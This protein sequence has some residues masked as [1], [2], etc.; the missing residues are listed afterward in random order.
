MTDEPSR[1]AIATYVMARPD[2]P[3]ADH[4][5]RALESRANGK[6]ILLQLGDRFLGD[7]VKKLLQA[8]GIEVLEETEAASLPPGSPLIPIPVPMYLVPDG[9]G[10]IVFNDTWNRPLV[11]AQAV[12]EALASSPS[13]QR[14][15]LDSRWLCWAMSYRQWRDVANLRDFVSWSIRLSEISN[16]D[17]LNLDDV[18][19][20]FSRSGQLERLFTV[21]VDPN[22]YCFPPGEGRGPVVRERVS[23]FASSRGIPQEY[24]LIDAV[25]IN[26]EFYLPGALMEIA[27]HV[28]PTE[29]WGND[30]YPGYFVD[31]RD[32]LPFL[33]NIDWW[34]RK[35]GEKQRN[36][37]AELN[38][39][40]WGR[41]QMY[42]RN[43]W[44]KLPE[45]E[46]ANLVR[47][48]VEELRKWKSEKHL[49]TEFG[50]KDDGYQEW[51]RAREA[52]GIS[53]LADTEKYSPKSFSELEFR[54]VDLDTFESS[55]NGGQHRRRHNA[56]ELLLD[57]EKNRK[58]SVAW[59]LLIGCLDT[60]RPKSEPGL[61][62]ATVKKQYVS[63]IRAGLRHQFKL[64]D[65]PFHKK[66]PGKGWRLT[67]KVIKPS[68]RTTVDTTRSTPNTRDARAKKS[69][70]S[71]LVAREH[72]AKRKVTTE[73]PD[74]DKDGHSD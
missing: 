4:L 46:L 69:Y 2:S 52:L 44:S 43:R 66:E 35:I 21:D 7:L 63:K 59:V 32:T 33:R 70:E 8:S 55:C 56:T 57:N 5:V 61:L 36:D 13:L 67:S 22:L 68:D 48:T 16:S 41:V 30:I 9:P 62:P 47:L 71:A 10:R 23:A 49:E 42:C 34:E 73:F 64:D 74:S 1:E 19:G 25:R 50:G 39:D 6:K 29:R 31:P 40:D 51:S 12:G 45:Q 14:L 60:N 54:Y 38:Q 37:L 65:D 18:L 20:E 53:D 15:A 26:W 28:R 58:P 17:H 27:Y 3:L 24:P 72:L 11:V